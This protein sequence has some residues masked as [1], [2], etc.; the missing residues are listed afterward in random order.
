MAS[1]GLASSSYP[2]VF[3]LRRRRYVVDREG[4]LVSVAQ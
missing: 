2:L 4:E 3:C 1:L